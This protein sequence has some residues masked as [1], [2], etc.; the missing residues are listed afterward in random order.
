MFRSQRTKYTV[1][2]VTLWYRAPELLLEDA[3]Y[4]P[5]I[6]IWSVGCVFGELI[7]KKPLF[8]SKTDAEHL[9]TVTKR[10][11]KK[12]PTEESWPGIS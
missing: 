9:S 8:P 4:S 5:K 7:S 1:K 11:G 10:L 3:Y 12:L 2:V 6:D